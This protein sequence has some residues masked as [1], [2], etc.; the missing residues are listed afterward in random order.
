LNSP[1]EKKI[2]KKRIKEALNDVVRQIY[3]EVIGR[4][5]ES[6]LQGMVSP[7]TEV[8]KESRF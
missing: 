3:R 6:N 4:G 8:K 7:S 1:A 5:K 2:K